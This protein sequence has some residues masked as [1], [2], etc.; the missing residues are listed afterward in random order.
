MGVQL[1]DDYRIHDVVADSLVDFDAAIKSQL[2]Y[3]KMERGKADYR[4]WDPWLIDDVHNILE[5]AEH[6]M[7]RIDEKTRPT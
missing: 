7:T 1:P 4:V 2:E 6:I 5:V 3:L